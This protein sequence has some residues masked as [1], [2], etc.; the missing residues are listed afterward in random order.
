MR[1]DETAGDEKPTVG[2]S[3]AL[4]REFAMNIQEIVRSCSHEKVAAAALASLGAPFRETVERAA[5]DR[6]KSAGA[7]TV[8]CVRRFD[9]IA[10][11][12]D[13]HVLADRIEGADMPVLSG[14]RHILETSLAGHP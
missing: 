14:L 2:G 8:D 7:F 6:G 11:E 3:A 4:H 12:R 13:F 9:E 10:E 1:A 5:A